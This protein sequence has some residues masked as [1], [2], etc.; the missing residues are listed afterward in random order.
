MLD[1]SR[2][3]VFSSVLTKLEIIHAPE[4]QQIHNSGWEEMEQLR[5]ELNPSNLEGVQNQ[6][7]Y[8]SSRASPY[9]IVLTSHCDDLFF[10]LVQAAG[11]DLRLKRFDCSPTDGDCSSLVSNLTKQ[12]RVEFSEGDCRQPRGSTCCDARNTTLLLTRVVQFLITIWR[13]SS[14]FRI[15]TKF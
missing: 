8:G 1:N 4:K 15:S 9:D 7:L 5:S 12:S 6:T 10:L 13:R 3:T 14:C 11:Q 2:T